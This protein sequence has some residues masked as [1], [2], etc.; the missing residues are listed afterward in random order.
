MFLVKY[1]A[2]F[3]GVWLGINILTATVNGELWT[4]RPATEA[5]DSLSAFESDRLIL[6]S[7]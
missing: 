5:R 2:I 4:H 1:C 6:R 7:R 3:K